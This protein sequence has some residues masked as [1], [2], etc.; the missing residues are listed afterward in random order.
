MLIIGLCTCRWKRFNGTKKWGEKIPSLNFISGRH[1]FRPYWYSPSHLQMKVTYSHV[2]SRLLNI[3]RDLF[4]V[5]RGRFKITAQKGVSNISNC[6]L[7]NPCVHTC[8]CSFCSQSH[9]GCWREE[10]FKKRVQ[11]LWPVHF[12][13]L[14][15]LTYSILIRLVLEECT[16]RTDFYTHMSKF[17]C[18]AH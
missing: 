5:W 3:W 1:N 15:V 8:F 4:L 11:R 13:K 2:I 16:S 10:M 18:R 12:P 14:H 6:Y 9:S 17:S 7:S